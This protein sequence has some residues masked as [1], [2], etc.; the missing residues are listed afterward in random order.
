[1]LVSW[2]AAKEGRRTSIF[3]VSNTDE[4]GSEI[5]D[6]VVSNTD[7]SGFDNIEAQERS[8]EEI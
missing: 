6:F 7:E 8:V 5:F 4:D 2:Y 3:V 1:M